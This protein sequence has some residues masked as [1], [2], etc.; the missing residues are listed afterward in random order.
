LTPENANKS[1]AE[2]AQSVENEV[3]RPHLAEIE[4]RL[5]TNRKALIKKSGVSIS[6]GASAATVAAL[7][8]VPL[9]IGGG[10]AALGAAVP[11]APLMHKYI[12]EKDVSIPMDEFYFLWSINKAKHHR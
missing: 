9:M 10:I 1:A 3:L 2:V 8:A 11:L 7:S 6:I 4:S 12:E 5:K